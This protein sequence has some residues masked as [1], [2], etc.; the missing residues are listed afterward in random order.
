M[1]VMMKYMKDIR[2]KTKPIQAGVLESVANTN[3]DKKK[4]L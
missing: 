2:N 1:V 3:E 4:D